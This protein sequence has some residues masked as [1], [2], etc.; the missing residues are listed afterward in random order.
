MTPA[1][2]APAAAPPEPCAEPADRTP[3]LPDIAIAGAVGS[4]EEMVRVQQIAVITRWLRFFSAVTMLG[5]AHEQEP[6]GQPDQA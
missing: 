1:P 3:P 2:A 5:T 6:P 4:E